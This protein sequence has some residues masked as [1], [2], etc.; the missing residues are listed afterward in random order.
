MSKSQNGAEIIVIPI[1]PPEFSN[2]IYPTKV[3]AKLEYFDSSNSQICRLD[4]AITDTEEANIIR[5][6][7]IIEEKV[8][9][10]LPYF[11]VLTQNPDKTGHTAQEYRLRIRGGSFSLR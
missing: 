1:L 7:Q 11:A 9:V 2:N 3:S 6:V 10:L 8:P 4:S 5:K